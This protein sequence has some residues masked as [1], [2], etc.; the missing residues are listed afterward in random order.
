MKCHLNLSITPPVEVADASLP[1]LPLHLLFPISRA[2]TMV[3]LAGI[4][5]DSFFSFLTE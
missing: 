5:N 4:L 3:V 1:G 2:R